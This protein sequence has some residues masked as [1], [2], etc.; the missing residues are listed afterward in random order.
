MTNSKSEATIIGRKNIALYALRPTILRF[1]RTARTRAKQIENGTSIIEGI[2]IY[3]CCT[4]SCSNPDRYCIPDDRTEEM[5]SLR[6][7]GGR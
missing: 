6:I 4:A 1:K 5:G 2:W 7:G 3:Y